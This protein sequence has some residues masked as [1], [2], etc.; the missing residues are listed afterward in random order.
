MNLQLP[1]QLPIEPKITNPLTSIQ[2][3]LVKTEPANLVKQLK[4]IGK[5]QTDEK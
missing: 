5:E 2:P 1:Q 4:P 3:M